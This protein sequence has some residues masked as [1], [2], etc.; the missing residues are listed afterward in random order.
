MVFPNA[1]RRFPNTFVPLEDISVSGVLNDREK[2]IA[3]YADLRKNVLKC[4]KESN[5]WCD[6]YLDA[7]QKVF[8]VV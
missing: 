6:S 5:H 4:R 8:L 2:L 7:M 3:D 1:Q